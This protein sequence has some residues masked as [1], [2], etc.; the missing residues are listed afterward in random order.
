M[1]VSLAINRCCI[2]K[3]VSNQIFTREQNNQAGKKSEN[4]IKE[5]KKDCVYKQNKKQRK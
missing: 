4:K 3:L 2:V 5:T 1:T